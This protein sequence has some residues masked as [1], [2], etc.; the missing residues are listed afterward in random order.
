MA[1]ILGDLDQRKLIDRRTTDRDRRAREVYLT[2]DGKR[3][4]DPATIAMRE[5]LRRAYRDAG[6][7]AVSGTRTVL[8][9]LA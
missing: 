7:T 5:T 9:A 6:A 3:V 2:E 8:E 1:R 4:T